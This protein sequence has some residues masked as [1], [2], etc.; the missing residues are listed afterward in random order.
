M[1]ADDKDFYFWNVNTVLHK[2]FPAPTS[3]KTSMVQQSPEL[4]L[5]RN[6]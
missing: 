5:L 3:H 4:S 6:V 2:A 1:S